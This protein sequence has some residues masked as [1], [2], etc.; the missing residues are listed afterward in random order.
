MG[1]IV[2]AILAIGAVSTGAVGPT[3]AFAAAILAIGG[4]VALAAYGISLLVDSFSG[5]VDSFTN[6]EMENLL[7]LIGA[8][9]TLA[10]LGLLAGLG[11]AGIAV[12][13]GLVAAAL[14]F[15]RDDEIDLLTKLFNS[16]GSVK[17]EA[18]KTIKDLASNLETLT[19]VTIPVKL[20]TFMGE[21]GGIPESPGLKTAGV[22]MKAVSQTS[23]AAA[24][25]AEGVMK[26]AAT[27]AQTKTTGE[28]TA[29]LAVIT[30]LLGAVNK[31]GA[32]PAT[33]AAGAAPAS[34]FTINLD[35][36]KVWKGM[37]P[38]IEGELGG[39]R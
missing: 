5:L 23:P 29:L 16:V 27:L 9:A 3:W 8:V 35:G 28:T 6:I 39:K 13:I 31:L 34:E 17:L 11:L 38:Y 2:L 33:A 1:G 20:S 18:A 37:V 30:K 22:F 21:L 32:Q 4:A 12:G 24:K 15:I 25:A 7:G 10:S 19:D 14:L 36:K 26:E